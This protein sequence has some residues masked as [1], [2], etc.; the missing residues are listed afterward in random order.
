VHLALG[1]IV[2][3][4]LG[5]IPFVGKFVTVAVVMIGLGAL[6]STRAAGLIKIRGGGGP[7]AST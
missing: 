2:Y 5:A 7:A 3:L 6:V 1:C 4:A